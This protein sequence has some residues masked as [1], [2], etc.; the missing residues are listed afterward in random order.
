MEQVKLADTKFWEDEATSAEGHARVKAKVG[1]MHCTLCTGIV[2][3]A[4]REQPGVQ[5]VSVSLPHEQALIEYDRERVRLEQLLGMLRDL[6]FAIGDRRAARSA[7]EDTS[8]LV[9][10]GRRL[11]AL[12]CLSAVTVPLMFLEMWNQVGGWVAWVVGAFAILTFVLAPQ[13]LVMTLE[14]RQ[15][16]L[17]SQAPVVRASALG[18]LVGGVIGVVFRPEHYPTGGFFAVTV[19]VVAYYTFSR[20]LALLVRTHSSHSV[21][22]LLELQPDTVRLVRDGQE[23][24]VPL[25][26]VG[27]GDRIRVRPGER[28]PIDGR[29]ASGRSAM[30]ES[31]VTG[32]SVPQQKREG[33]E[34]IGGSI[35]GSGTL[36]VEVTRVGKDTFLQRVIRSVED[37]RAL[38]PR[39]LDLVARVLK[40]YVPS[41]LWLAALAAVFWVV[42]PALWGD[43]PELDRAVFATLSVLIMAYPCAVGMA[44]P[45]ALVRGSGDAAERGIVL[46]TGEAFQTFGSVTR[47]VFDKTGT[48]TEGAFTVR[49]VEA[50]GDRDRLLALAAAAEASSEHPVGAAIVAA[51][52]ERGLALGA[53]QEFEAISG[54]GVRATIDGAAVLVGRPSFVAERVGHLGG[55]AERVAALEQAG[56]T[57]VGVSRDGEILGLIALGDQI[58]AEARAAVD[59]MKRQ[60]ITPVLVTG[61]NRPAAERVA[62]ELAIDDVRAE[63]LPDGKAE[64]VRDLQRH[65]RV[66]MVGDGINDAPALT[67]ADVGIAMGSGTDIAIESAD[68]IIV[69]NRLEAVL[70]ARDI[71][72]RSYRRLQQNVVLAFL[73]NGVGVP[74]AATGLLYPIWAMVVMIVSVTAVLANSM[75]GK[76]S[77]MFS[78][79]RD[80][81]KR[82]VYQ[83]SPTA[84]AGARPGSSRAFTH[85]AGYKPDHRAY[86]R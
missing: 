80:V 56:R 54:H 30:D 16:G 5:R 76:W 72:R 9:S 64:I 13:L 7:P 25:K 17:L 53:A 15:R 41:V 6:G 62:R 59:E 1:G 57:V 40:V 44:A 35:N 67:Q 32:E 74:L 29:V 65:G 81:A 20:W 10:E 26:A 12:F 82:Q 33:D 78:T 37:A 24:E 70:T 50:T 42:V 23:G 18:G 48:L 61:D 45:L 75:R 79:L 84:S 69:G 39:I 34:V 19:L 38:K 4:L 52:R 49:E 63:V 2:E 8:A 51:A 11:L 85:K 28:V 86:H 71:G 14:S 60:G 77:M 55:L 47:I 73:F 31:L 21:E 68:V 43:G 46:R 66:A 22:K 36:L 27:V 3:R 58:R 83:P